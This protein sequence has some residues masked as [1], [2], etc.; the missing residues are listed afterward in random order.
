MNLTENALKALGARYLLKDGR[1]KVIETP[2]G[3]FRRV[4]RTIA[5]AETQY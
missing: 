2:E 4:A 3:M 1:G 5:A